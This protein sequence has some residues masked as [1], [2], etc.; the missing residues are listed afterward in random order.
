MSHRLQVTLDD[1]LY[2]ALQVE[3]R[4][5]GASLAELVRRSVS[6]RL[7]MQS[8]G[9]RLAILNRTAG[10]WSPSGE[11]GQEFQ[12]EQRQGLTERP[13]AASSSLRPGRRRR[14]S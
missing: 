6:D 12:R 10:A 7:G 9:D 8:V 14:T 13:R 1:D 2:E 3:A 4:Q 5:T 11:T